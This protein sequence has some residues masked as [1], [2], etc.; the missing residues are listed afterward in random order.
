[1]LL[2]MNY[3]RELCEARDN[4]CTQFL[5]RSD[6]LQITVFHC[7]VLD[8]TIMQLILSRNGYFG[9]LN[10]AVGVYLTPLL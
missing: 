5:E 6:I 3:A 2:G 4:C 8:N 9:S 10:G 7:I 1:M